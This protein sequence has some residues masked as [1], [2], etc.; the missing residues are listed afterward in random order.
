MRKENRT[1][2]AGGRST[3]QDRENAK[4]HLSIPVSLCYIST[5]EKFESSTYRCIATSQVVKALSSELWWLHVI[6]GEL[7]A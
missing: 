1:L 7:E 4:S 6:D 5:I 3:L 2:E